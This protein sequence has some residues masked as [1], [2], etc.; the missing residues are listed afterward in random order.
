ML[1][2][3][4]ITNNLEADITVESSVCSHEPLLYLHYC[5]LTFYIPAS[6]FIFLPRILYSCVNSFLLKAKRILVL[7][8]CGILVYTL[9]KGF[10]S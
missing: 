4:I 6:G 8:V 10:Q 2:G 5:V 9:P 3:L 7:N 1:N